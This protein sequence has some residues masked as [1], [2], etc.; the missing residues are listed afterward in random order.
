MLMVQ[1]SLPPL[2]I[3]TDGAAAGGIRQCFQVAS[4]VAGAPNN[5]DIWVGLGSSLPLA[6]HRQEPVSPA[7]DSGRCLT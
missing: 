3:K 5:E 1:A 4:P 2:R 7:A 6:L